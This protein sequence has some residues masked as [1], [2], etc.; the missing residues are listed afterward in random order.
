MFLECSI[1][2]RNKDGYV[3][4]KKNDRKKMQRKKVA[5]TTLLTKFLEENYSNNSSRALNTSRLTFL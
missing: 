3:Y 2:S 4:Q 1:G 5:I